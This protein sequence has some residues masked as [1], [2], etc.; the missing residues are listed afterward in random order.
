MDVSEIGCGCE[1][2]LPAHP[3]DQRRALI[4][5]V[6]KFRVQQNVENFKKLSDFGVLKKN[7]ARCSYP[8]KTLRVEYLPKQ[9]HPQ[10]PPSIYVNHKLQYVTPTPRGSVVG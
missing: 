10:I 5:M 8:T 1:L 6:I 9:L 3:R 7:S 2:I 4:N